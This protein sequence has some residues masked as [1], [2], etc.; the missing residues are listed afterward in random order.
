MKSYQAALLIF[1]LICFAYSQSTNKSCSNNFTQQTCQSPCVFTPDQNSF[2]C[3]SK[4]SSLDQ[5]SCSSQSTCSY[6]PGYC[7]LS[8]N[9]C[10]YILGSSLTQDQCLRQNIN[11]VFTPP[12]KEDCTVLDNV[13]NSC[14]SK[15]NDYN[16]CQAIKNS[17]STQQCTFTDTTQ[18]CEAVSNYQCSSTP[19]CDQNMCDYTACAQ[20]PGTDCSTYK[21]SDNCNVSN[22]CLW[23]TKDSVCNDNCTNQTSTGCPSSCIKDQCVSNSTKQLNYCKALNTD[24]KCA[25]DSTRCKVTSLGT[26]DPSSTLCSVTKSLKDSCPSDSCNYISPKDPTCTNPKCSKSYSENCDPYCAAIPPRCISNGL[27]TCGTL[28]SQS[29]CNNSAAFCS[30]S[31]SGTC[32]TLATGSS[33]NSYILSLVLV[34]QLLNILF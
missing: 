21:T 4:C 23:S 27:S 32:A 18:K 8:I 6:Q 10:S 7:Q 20:K 14:N 17:A 2:V 3:Q 30:Y 22:N 31:Q 16:G 1:T 5:N 34:F 25:A 15:N 28:K 19:S 13:K 26:C 33:S 24:S 9:N 29:D 11:C 12:V